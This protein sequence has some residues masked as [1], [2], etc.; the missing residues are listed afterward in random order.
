MTFMNLATKNIKK[1]FKSYF[2]YLLSS[3]FSVMVFYMFSSIAYNKEFMDLCDKKGLLRIMFQGSAG[4]IAI[5]ALIFIG[6]ANSFFLK[7]RKKEIAIYSMVGMEKKQI[8]K[9]LFY[10]NIIIGTI[11]I[12]I[13]LAIGLLFSKFFAL[14]LVN[15][16]REAV[17]IKFSLAP[18][19]ITVTL[20]LF[21]GLF[22]INSIHSYRIIYKYK[23]IEL[24]MAK[25]QGEKKAKG[26]II[27]GLIAIASILFGYYLIIGK[28]ASILKKTVLPSGVLVILGSFMLFS[29]FI[30]LLLRTIKGKKNVYYRGVNM[31]SISQI[32]FRIRSNGKTLTVISLLCALTITAISGAYSMYKG[33]ELSLNR[34]IPFSYIVIKDDTKAYKEVEA[35]I[36]KYEDNK[37]IADVDVEGLNLDVTINEYMNKAFKGLVVHLSSYNSA[38]KAKNIQ[39]KMYLNDD[40]VLFVEVNQ[41]TSKDVNYIGKKSRIKVGDDEREFTIKKSTD[42]QFLSGYIAGGTLVLSDKAYNELYKMSINFAVKYKGYIINNQEKSKKLSEEI[43][44]SKYNDYVITSYYETYQGFY[45][46]SGSLIFIGT[47]LGI[48]F[49]LA[50]GSIISFKQLMEA[51]EDKERYS[52]LMR[53]GVSKKE[54]SS[55]IYR[56]LSI[57]FGLPL[58]LALCHSLVGIKVYEGLMKEKAIEYYGLVAGIYLI[59]YIGYYIFTSNIYSKIVCEK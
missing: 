8:G 15:I 2:M 24:L 44:K 53:I 38:L 3:V 39:D 43:T 56:Q 30:P 40:E 22:L 46:S 21:L 26:S 29:N 23:L 19:A 42:K 33:T 52:S 58:I 17:V 45:K 55:S 18:K 37:I 34:D 16:M 57:T 31:L 41:G 25:K 47:F 12:T 28:S 35:I 14:M 6:Y 49:F 13:G 7:G 5:F 54:I 32:L 11:A 10:E 20:I 59:L 36:N 27:L 1:S 48:M 4:V 51:E 50:T 9:M